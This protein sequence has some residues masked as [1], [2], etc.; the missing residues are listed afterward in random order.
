[1]STDVSFSKEDADAIKQ[2]FIAEQNHLGRIINANTDAAEI[3]IKAG[4]SG[5]AKKILGKAQTTAVTES[6]RMLKAEGYSQQEAANQ[7]ALDND[8]FESEKKIEIA[9]P[10]GSNLSNLLATLNFNKNDASSIVS[11][12]ESTIGTVEF[13]ES[14][15]GLNAKEM[16]EK[17]SEL[18]NQKFNN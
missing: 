2:Q 10:G 14:L 4:G 9:G 13:L 15:V 17:F 3:E 5:E 18:L 8:S 16:K 6:V 11:L 7:A 12:M 1:M